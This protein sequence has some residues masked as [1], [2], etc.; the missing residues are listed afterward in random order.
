MLHDKP[1][2]D[3][4]GSQLKTQNLLQIVTNYLLSNSKTKKCDANGG[5]RLLSFI[6][7]VLKRVGCSSYE[8]LLL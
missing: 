4:F 1:S 7:N 3:C 2:C 5:W 6:V 8:Q